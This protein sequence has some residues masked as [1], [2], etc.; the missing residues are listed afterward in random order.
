MVVGGSERERTR[1]LRELAHAA[2]TF[3]LWTGKRPPFGAVLLR[4][5]EKL[6]SV[7]GRAGQWTL[8]F[9]PQEQEQVERTLPAATTTNAS[10]KLTPPTAT[11]YDDGDLSHEVCHRYVAWLAMA[12]RRPAPVPDM[13]NEAAAIS[14]EPATMREK[15]LRTARPQSE[16]PTPAEILTTRNPLSVDGALIA[17]LDAEAKQNGSSVVNFVIDPSD[18]LSDAVAAFYTKSTLLQG[19]ARSN[20]GRGGLR[21]F[22]ILITQAQG[23]TPATRRALSGLLGKGQTP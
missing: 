22:E 7:T 18:K 1:A 16:A 14:C 15:R 19:R 12:A 23:N 21:V 8:V 11:A 13:I 4:T 9:D 20:A 3:Q 5:S 10:V 6:P 2:W 17:R